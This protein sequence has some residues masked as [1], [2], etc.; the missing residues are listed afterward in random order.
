MKEI[1]IIHDNMSKEA[2]EAALEALMDTYDGSERSFR[3]GS[4]PG[5]C[6]D[7][8]FAGIETTG[9]TPRSL[10]LKEREQIILDS[11]EWGHLKKQ[12]GDPYTAHHRIGN[13]KRL[14]N[15]RENFRSK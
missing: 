11:L 13:Q 2:F 14:K 6:F 1:I 3:I 9:F 4:M 7:M 5:D 10:E 12:E 15:K 8:D